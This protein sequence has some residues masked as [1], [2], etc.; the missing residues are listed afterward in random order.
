MLENGNSVKRI[1]ELKERLEAKKI[2]LSSNLVRVEEELRAVSKTLDLL[3]EKRT[4]TRRGQNV[5]L[6]VRPEEL[7]GMT[8]LQALVHI[9]GRNNHILETSP[10]RLLLI[11]AG[12]LRDGK[13]SSRTLYLTVDRSNRFQSVKR[14]HYVL[15]DTAEQSEPAVLRPARVS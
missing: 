9:A 1:Y 7:K 3:D 12:L 11:E 4:R 10:A 2:V 15:L 6:G 13:N 5:N 14:G 8:Q